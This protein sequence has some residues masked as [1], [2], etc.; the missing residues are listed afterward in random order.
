MTKKHLID[1]VSIQLY[2]YTTGLNP[3]VPLLKSKRLKIYG[4]IKW[5]K[6]VL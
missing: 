5:N 2:K 4:H 3:I 1:Y 6:K